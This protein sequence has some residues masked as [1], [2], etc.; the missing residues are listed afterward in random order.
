MDSN[1]MVDF[2]QFS[3]AKYPVTKIVWD[4]VRLWAKDNGYTDLAVGR[5]KGRQPVGCI[6]WYDAVKF[7][8][9]LSELAGLEPCYYVKGQVYRNGMCD[10]TEKDRKDTNG[11]R[12]PLKEEWIQ[13]AGGKSTKYFWGEEEQPGRDLYA[14][15]DKNAGE[16]PQIVGQKL[17]NPYGLYDIIGNVYEWCFDKKENTLRVMMGGSVA[18]DAILATEFETFAPADYKCYETGLRV[19]S[20]WNESKDVETVAKKSPFYG[21][22][23][24][25]KPIYPDMSEKAIAAR[26]KNELGEDAFSLEIK[27]LIDAGKYQTAFVAFR[28]AKLER[29]K[30]T[31][32]KKPENTD[33]MRRS[34][35]ELFRISDVFDI[36]FW[37]GNFEYDVSHIFSELLVLMQRYRE[38]ADKR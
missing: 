7:C 22:E 12:L 32:K 8:N 21:T 25:P 19:F 30:E 33:A 5:G 17:P 9:A 31:V 29:I 2:G 13:A 16:I 35:E 14:W 15:Y 38:K 20:G 36:V 6:T 3:A 18:L 28:N 1:K 23:Q 27:G 4:A 24:W 34:E 26:L 37:K 11:Y 10:I